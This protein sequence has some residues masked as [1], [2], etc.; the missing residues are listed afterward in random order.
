MKPY[1]FSRRQIA[2]C[3]C[4]DCGVNVIR[5][6][7]YC[8]L[9]FGL[10][11]DELHLGWHDNL[12]IVCIEERLGRRLVHDDFAGFPSVE[13]FVMSKTLSDRIIGNHVVLKGGECVARDSRRGRAEIYRK[14]RQDSN[15]RQHMAAS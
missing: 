1:H 5:A 2:R 13:G 6:G 14:A 12:C 4:L 10:W 15:K 8:L 9:D 7:D 3:K 11:D